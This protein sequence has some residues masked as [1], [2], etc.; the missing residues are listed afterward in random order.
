M[1]QVQAPRRDA[2]KEAETYEIGKAMGD[3]MSDNSGK[4]R[5]EAGEV[6]FERNE[7]GSVTVY[8]PNNRGERMKLQTIDP[9]IWASVIATLSYYGEENYGYY[10]ATNFHLGTPI[11]DGML[12]HI[13]ATE[14][15]R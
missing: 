15:G 13:K 4:V 10:R 11:G 3:A 8:V 12:P 14:H 2:E 7:S 6:L 9:S 1:R 5:V